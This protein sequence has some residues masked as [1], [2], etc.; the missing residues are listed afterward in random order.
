METVDELYLLAK[1]L[2]I[3]PRLIVRESGKFISAV[4]IVENMIQKNYDVQDIYNDVITKDINHNINHL[5]IAMIYYVLASVSSDLKQFVYDNLKSDL[6]SYFNEV[7]TQWTANNV[8]LL[9]DLEDLKINIGNYL[10]QGYE[11]SEIIKNIGFNKKDVIMVYYELYLSQ[12]EDLSDEII[13]SIYD[14]DNW[15]LESYL[16]DKYSEWE[17]I[18]NT[19]FDD[20]NRITLYKW[21]YHTQIKIGKEF[22]IVF[23]LTRPRDKRD[24]LSVSGTETL[25]FESLPE[26][27]RGEITQGKQNPSEIYTYIQ[28]YSKNLI[29][30]DD[31][32]MV[33]YEMYNNGEDPSGIVSLITKQ[34]EERNIAEENSDNKKKKFKDPYNVVNII[35]RFYKLMGS[36][37]IGEFSNE[38]DLKIF[39]GERLKLININIAND[40]DN[41]KLMTNIYIELSELNK[42]INTITTSEIRI[43]STLKSFNPT[44]NGRVVT[45]EDGY[46]IF[47]KSKISQHIPFICYN[48]N[49]G[50]S[51]YKVFNSR[52]VISEVNNYE[53]IMH[54]YKFILSPKDTPIKN[55]IYMTMWLGDINET[56]VFKAPQKS[57]YIVIYHLDGN[58]LTI[59]STVKDPENDIF[60]LRTQAYSY[61]QNGL[62]SITLGRGF[63]IKTR[64]EFDI[65][66]QSIDETI[67]V[68]LILTDDILNKYL[69]IDESKKAF[70]VKKRL[71][72]QYHNLFIENMSP[73]VSFTITNKFGNLHI[74]VIQAD[75]ESIE[76]YIYIFRLLMVRYNKLY[77]IDT[78]KQEYESFLPG[79]MN[80]LQKLINDQT[81]K[82]PEK[83][84]KK[85]TILE[86]KTP[87]SSDNK[88][89]AK[90]SKGHNIIKTPG[91]SLSSGTRGY[92]S[93]TL[94]NILNN[95]YDDKIRDGF[96]FYRYGTTNYTINSLLH[97]VCFAI[98]DPN[99]MDIDDEAGKEEYIKLLKLYILNNINI[100]VMRQE[101]FDY[102]DSEIKELF[103]D[104]TKF[105][106]PALIYRAVEETFNIN[107]YVFTFD[108]NK[109]LELPRYKIFHSR[110][111]REYR[112]TV[113]IMKILAR[114]SNII[115]IPKCELIVDFN[116]EKYEIVKIF[117]ESITNI[118]HGLILQNYSNIVTIS[119]SEDENNYLAR[120][121]IYYHLDNIKI[122]HSSIQSQFID[123]NGKMKAVNIHTR[124]GLMTVAIQPSQP[125]N[126]P[127]STNII[128][129]SIDDVIEI[130]GIPSGITVNS[131][132]YID[133]LW[134]KI[135][136]ITYGEYIPIE[137]VL[138][139]PAVSKLIVTNNPLG[140]VTINTTSRLRKL[141]RT[142]NIVIEL[143][144][145]C[146]ILQISNKQTTPYAFQQEYFEVRERNVDSVD[147]YDLSKI[148][149][150]LPDMLGRS[151]DDAIN[152]MSKLVP[153]LFAS[154]K[155]IMYSNDFSKKIKDMLIT[156]DM[157]VNVPKI[158]IK[159]HE[160]INNFYESIDDYIMAANTK[161]FLSRYDLDT[162]L[163]SLRSSQNDI[164]KL[165]VNVD[166][167]KS[168]VLEPY[169][170]QTK[171]KHIYIIQNTPD[172]NSNKALIIGKLWDKEKINYGLD[173]MVKPVSYPHYV[174]GISSNSELYVIADNTNNDPNYLEVLYYGQHFEYNNGTNAKYA[175]MLKLI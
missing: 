108:E 120:N 28:E 131:K 168:L 60:T 159:I 134:Y 62:P 36:T 101:L 45:P 80:K 107:L 82:L 129:S 169:I 112:P 157:M 18:N 163:L 98:D 21:W 132:D 103:L 78:V 15:L 9:D 110:P 150:K 109:T 52:E 30:E 69:Y 117:G 122:F 138:N 151:V 95:Y 58:K 59:D 106:D 11:L 25:I 115:E 66:Q 158:K 23:S 111:A 17:A 14:N 130:F 141:K 114:E 37:K 105:F 172:Y 118:C 22:P 61:A 156:Y 84:T 104:D 76:M 68:D 49:Y 85:L 143:I 136:D 171:E 97:C 38:E 113:L 73:A 175:A 39:Y 13:L 6:Y 27:L 53:N 67:L 155:I 161:L 88:V 79:I 64:F 50:K 152:Y 124:Y 94:E 5:D 123:N 1:N 57:F 63:D 42:D 149:R 170:F 90:S 147:Y 99:Y 7:Y 70:A 125:E 10:E 3:L 81:K 47:N 29:N 162:W 121:N 74:N 139:H 43:N 44:L 77:E 133:G 8:T 144:K 92:I 12:N 51:V 145:W 75:P 2:Q 54:R 146:Y 71:D 24:K 128:R 119:K 135:L 20:S 137:P 31:I 164:Q 116:E 87:K 26:I 148:E 91:K 166:V 93:K 55:T 4:N 83:Q 86:P 19:K 96:K 34:L 72:V 102:N 126:L 174:Y 32:A 140:F 35:N 142:L 65:F 56:S 160:T 48:D 167:S 40:Y 127:I 100:E 89:L 153:T 173:V 46:D 154:G 33:F 165:N 41:F 16:S